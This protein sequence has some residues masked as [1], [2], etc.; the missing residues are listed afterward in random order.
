MYREPRLR[1]MMQQPSDVNEIKRPL[2]K[3]LFPDVMGY[4]F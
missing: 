4:K 3:T 1:K 2:R